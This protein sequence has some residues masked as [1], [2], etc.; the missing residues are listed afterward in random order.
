MEK[1]IIATDETIEVYIYGCDVCRLGIR[2][3]RP[4]PRLARQEQD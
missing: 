1:T 3:E 2:E 4:Y